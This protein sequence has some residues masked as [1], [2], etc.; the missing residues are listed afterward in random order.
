M[1]IVEAFN[2]SKFSKNLYSKSDFQENFQR[3]S[4]ELGLLGSKPELLK[5]KDFL[6]ILSY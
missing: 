2:K 6:Y 1:N 3:V 5:I 4:E